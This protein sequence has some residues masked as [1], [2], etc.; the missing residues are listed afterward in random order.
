MIKIDNLLAQI[1]NYI[2]LE[3]MILVIVL[4]G[5]GMM[6]K[7]LNKIKD[8]LIPF[9]LLPIGV[10]LA[11]LEQH[12]ISSTSFMQGIICVM[13]ACYGNQLIKQ[14][15]ELIDSYKEKDE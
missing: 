3:L 15:V 12:S 14:G 4:Y 7:G 1:N 9:I 13:V 5:I 6:L 11:M 8:C 2:P 10:V